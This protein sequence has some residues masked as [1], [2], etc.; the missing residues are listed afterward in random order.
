VPYKQGNL[1]RSLGNAIL[2]LELRLDISNSMDSLLPAL[3]LHRNE[4]LAELRQNWEAAGGKRGN[5][6]VKEV[7]H[8]SRRLTPA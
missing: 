3:V 2:I 1:Q 7:V 8:A 5:I 4:L 6:F